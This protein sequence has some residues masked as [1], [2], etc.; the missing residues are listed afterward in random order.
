MPAASAIADRR[1]PMRINQGRRD[2][3]ATLSAAG[4][5]GVLGARKSPAAEGLLETT[6]SGSAMSFEHLRCP[7][8]LADDLLRGKGSPISTICRPLAGRRCTRRA[9]LRLQFRLAGLLPFLDAGEPI[10]ALAGLHPG[11]YELFAQEP[12]RTI[13]DLKGKRFG[14]RQLGAASTCSWRSWQRMSGS[15]LERTSIGSQA[16]S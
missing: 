9:R 15:T 1:L 13:S 6:S 7:V 3:L 12:I 8:L 14:V 4:A 16:R 5:A 2:F 11:C 10:T